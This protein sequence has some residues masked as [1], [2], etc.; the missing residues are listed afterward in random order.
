PEQVSL[1]LTQA[2][3]ALDFMNKRQHM[4]EGRRIAF[5][6]CDVKPSN[7]LLFGDRV[8][9]SDFGLASTTS[10]MMKSHSR[11]GTLEYAAPEVFQGRLSEWTDQYALAV[12]YC[13]LRG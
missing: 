4:L 11:S 9:L 10:S 6:H 7:M 12:T 1:N 3:D 5:Q 8:K 2:A 13:L